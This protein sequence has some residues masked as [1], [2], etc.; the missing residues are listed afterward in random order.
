MKKGKYV[1]KQNRDERG[2][3]NTIVFP[4]RGENIGYVRKKES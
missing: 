4:V 1:K 3:G 2:R